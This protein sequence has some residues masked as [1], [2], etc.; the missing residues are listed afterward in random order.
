MYWLIETEEQISYLINRGFKEAYIEIIPFSN[1]VHPALND[2]SLVY[3]R[4]S[5]ERKGF[6]L[7]I[8]HSE[9]LSIEL[10][11]VNELLQG[12]ERLYVQD[13][14]NA[15]FYFPIKGLLDVDLIS[16]PYIPEPTA[17]HTI[18]SSRLKH[19]TDINRMIPVVKHYEVSETTYNAIKHTFD[20]PRPLHFDFYNNQATFAF[21]GIEVNGLK[22]DKNEFNKHFPETEEDFVYT[23]YNFKTLTTRPSNR[24]GGINFAALP[25]DSGVRK[26]F[27]PRNDLFVEIDISAYHPTLAASLVGYTF[28]HEDIHASFAEMYKVD[29]KKAKELTFKQL[30]GG[31]FEQYKELEFFKKVSVYIDNLWNDYTE[32]GWIESPTSGYQFCEDKLDSMNPQK[33]FNYVLQNLETSTNVG[34]LM[35]IHKLLRGKKTKIVL[36]TYDSFLFDLAKD[37]E[38]I[39]TEIKEI[40]K[41]FELNIK[42]AHGTSYDFTGN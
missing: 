7:C 28:D 11:R 37:E 18:L 10:T 23:Q 9:T 27:V 8:D 15:L 31:V 33:L 35:Q 4:P 12:I 24:F 34:I 40:F 19:R 17:T 1:N 20:A 14:K 30:Y 13:K 26:A 3:F 39:L 25:H 16:N 32:N 2:I 38:S 41:K 36:Y 42:V 29:Y 21:F 22:I 5:I 6:M